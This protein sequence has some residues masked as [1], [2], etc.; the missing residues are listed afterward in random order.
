VIRGE[1][2]QQNLE[3]TILQVYFTITA[4]YTPTVIN[5][6]MRVAQVFVVRSSLLESS[7]GQPNAGLPA[8]QKTNPLTIQ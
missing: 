4:S 6:N 1:A 5:D 3:L 2:S 8:I 7:K